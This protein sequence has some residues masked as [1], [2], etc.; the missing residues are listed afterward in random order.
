MLKHTNYPLKG[1][2]TFGVEAYAKEYIEVHSKEA[3]KS[4]F[5]NN[6]GKH[7][8]LGGG[9]NVL[10]CGDFDGMVIR[11]AIQG[12]KVIGKKPGKV[13]LEVSAGEDWDDLVA[14]CVDQNWGGLENLSRI[15]GQVGS[16][17]IQNIGAY[18]VELKD[19]FQNLI[20]FDKEKKE[21][22]VFD[23]EACRF[24]YRDSFFKHDGKNRFVITSVT[25]AL[26]TRP[27]PQTAYGSLKF[28]LD[29]GGIDNPDINDIRQA[30]CR[31]RSRKLPNPDELGNAGSFFKNPVISEKKYLKLKKRF[32]NM[33]VFDDPKG[34]KL[35]AAWLIDQAGWKG[36]RQGDAGVH[37]QQALVLVNHGKATGN[38]IIQLAD[39][40]RQSVFEKYEIRLE[41]EVNII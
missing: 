11:I 14:Y 22:L 35:A 40:I 5:S 31:I 37:G 26:N 30:V 36:Y 6:P 21:F 38:D 15:P 34:K 39:Q 1:L 24:G 20:A 3:L 7:L 16:S 9:S 4:L 12:R 29:E 28:E 33:V 2:N 27:I 10:F 32:P 13:L 8:I 19:C 23:K 17:P 18:G 41:P 25:F